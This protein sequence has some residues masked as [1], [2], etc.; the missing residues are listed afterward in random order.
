MKWYVGI[1]K[2]T[3]KYEKFQAKED[4]TFET[5]GHRYSCVVGPFDTQAGAEY[6][7]KYGPGNPHLCCVFDAER[8]A[9]EEAKNESH[10]S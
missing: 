5:H 3:L 1:I 9:E 10:H 4:P 6:M 2:D 7:E 8:Y